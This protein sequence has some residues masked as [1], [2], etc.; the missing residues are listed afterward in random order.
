[1]F[2]KANF[3]GMLAALVL[4]ASAAHAAPLYSI[5]ALPAN[6]FAYAIN[7]A[8]QVGGDVGVGAEG[9]AFIWAAGV[10]TDLG[11]AGTASSAR[12]VSRNGL[13]AGF[14]TS[15][16]QNR[17]FVHDGTGL[18]RLGTLGGANSTAH[19]VNALGQVAGQSNNA[20]GE[21]RGFIYSGGTMTD[22]GTLGGNFA[23]AA[24]INHAGQV[25]G[26]SAF[27][28]ERVSAVHAFIYENGSMRD[29]GTLGGSLSSA[30]AINDAGQIAGHS[31]TVGSVEHAFLYTGGMMIDLGTLG[32][33]RSF[34]YGINGLGQ[35]VGSS[36]LEGDLDMHAF[37]YSAGALTDLNALIDPASGWVLHEARGINDLGQIA[38]F[39]CMGEN[40]QAVLLDL[41]PQVPEPAA[42]LLMLAGLGALAAGRVSAASRRA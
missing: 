31:Y 16:E 27:D 29:L 22:L 32:G 11:S 37:I 39:G 14:T 40:C 6:T 26:E 15:S 3:A 7:N 8:G 41:V 33:G 17:A 2:F 42:V 38:A 10:L 20:A 25:V 12:A 30:A 21:F 5:T 19:A 23:Y 9:H 24:A 1:M 34:G 13:A 35:V 36:G 28:P 4:G 18:I